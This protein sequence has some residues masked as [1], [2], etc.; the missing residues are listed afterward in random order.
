MIYRFNSIEDSTAS[1]QAVL[2]KGE[3][4]AEASK[5]YR[6]TF[7]AVQR[8]RINTDMLSAG[9]MGKL[10]APTEDLRFTSSTLRLGTHDA[11]YK[12]YVA[13]VEMVNNYDGWEVH[14]NMH[15]KRND[16]QKY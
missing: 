9:F 6:N 11:N 15:Y 3:S 16:D 14:L 13:E 10:E 4:Y 12:N 8:T 2:F 5:I 1:W 7:K